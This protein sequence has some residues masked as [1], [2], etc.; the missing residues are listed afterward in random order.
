M[1]YALFRVRYLADEGRWVPFDPANPKVV[2][3]ASFDDPSRMRASPEEVRRTLFQAIEPLFPG[4]YRLD[5]T[6]AELLEERLDEVRRTTHQQF[7]KGFVYL[8]VRCAISAAAQARYALFETLADELD[9]PF[10]LHDTEGFADFVADTRRELGWFVRS[11]LAHCVDVLR[12]GARV[13]EAMKQI[14]SVE[15]LLDFQDPREPL[16]EYG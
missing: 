6:L 2:R 13:A 4:Y 10:R 9:F 14:D 3:L 8:G 15:A 5:W 11:A 12:E 16:P 1:T 7:D